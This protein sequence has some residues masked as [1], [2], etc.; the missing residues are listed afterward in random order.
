[1]KRALAS[2]LLALVVL[3]PVSAAAKWPVAKAPVIAKAPGYAAIP[4]AAVAP[5]PGT[6]YKA[7]FDASHFADSG[8]QLAPAIASASQALNALAAC[9]VP[10][11]NAKFVIIFHGA[12]LDALWENEA[13]QERFSIRNPNLPVLAKLRKAGVEL[14][15]CGQTLASEKVDARELSPDV[16]I[17][18]DASIVLMTYQNKGYALLGD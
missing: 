3:N 16:K 9:N 4:G 2:G 11:T 8:S 6:V 10:L 7:I 15:V 17:A 18:S 14:Y 12:S 13:Y 1:M 5:Q